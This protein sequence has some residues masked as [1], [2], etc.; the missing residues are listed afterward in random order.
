[1]K[2]VTTDLVS[3]DH[4]EIDVD[5]EEDLN[6]DDEAGS[7]IVINYINIQNSNC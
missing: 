3:K 4:T 2:T 5:G 7:L 1:M 6:E